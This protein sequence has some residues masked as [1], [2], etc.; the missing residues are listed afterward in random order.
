MTQVKYALTLLE[1]NE[2]ITME[3]LAKQIKK[4]HKNFNI[5]SQHLGKVLRDSNK[6]RKRT[7]HKHLC[8]ICDGVWNRDCNGATNIYKVSYNAIHNL[9]RPEYLCRGT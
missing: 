7:R 3:E 6:T 4:K 1:K 8:K 5:T 9:N 2:Q